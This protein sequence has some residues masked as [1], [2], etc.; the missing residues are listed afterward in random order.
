MLTPTRTGGRLRVPGGVTEM[1]QAADRLA[2]HAQRGL[3]AISTI[4]RAGLRHLRFGKLSPGSR[5]FLL[6][7]LEVD[8]DILLLRESEKFF[9]ALLSANSGL[10][11]SAERRANE[12]LGCVI[13]PNKTCFD[14]RGRAMRLHQIIRPDRAGQPVFWP[15]DLLYHHRLV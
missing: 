3:V 2:D 6:R 4:L 5:L 9:Q 12:M 13:Y 14:G 15:I 10:L 7:A 11:E 8:V 1:A